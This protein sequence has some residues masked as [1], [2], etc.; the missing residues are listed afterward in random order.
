[1][2]TMNNSYLITDTG[3]VRANAE[4]IIAS[5]PEGTKLIPVLKDDAYGLGIVPMAKA[6]C[7]LPEVEMLRPPIFP[8]APRFGTRE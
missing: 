4:H 7:S 6:L 5:L 2:K 8:K 3:A 1:M